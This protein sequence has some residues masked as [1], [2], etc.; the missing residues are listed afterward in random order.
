MVYVD[1]G[2]GMVDAIASMRVVLTNT[3]NNQKAKVENKEAMVKRRTRTRR[4]TI[5]VLKIA[6]PKTIPLENRT[7]PRRKPNVVS[8]EFPI[9][10]R[11]NV[12]RK[13]QHPN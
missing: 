11:R 6:K 10:T 4:K 1:I 2:G 8:V 12:A 9:T 3:M 13:L 7:L 5:L